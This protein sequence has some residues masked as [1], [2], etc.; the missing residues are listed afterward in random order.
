MK[1]S[2]V[3]TPRANFM[4]KKCLARKLV[5]VLGM[6]LDVTKVGWRV[7]REFGRVRGRD[8]DA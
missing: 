7:A 1:M 5:D 4:E 3:R 8:S 6:L 2:V